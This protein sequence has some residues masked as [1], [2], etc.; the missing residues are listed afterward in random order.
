MP[1]DHQVLTPALRFRV[2]RENRDH[3]SWAQ[4]AMKSSWSLPIF[5][6][7]SICAAQTV[8]NAPGNR[9]RPSPSLPSMG[10]VSDCTADVFDDCNAPQS[11]Q[12]LPKV[13]LRTT[14]GPRRLSATPLQ[15]ENQQGAPEL[16]LF[17]PSKLPA[18]IIN[19]SDFQ[20]FAEDD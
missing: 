2:L 15:L 19:P 5:L 17:T 1:H 3:K 9:A 16:G 10:S 20:L 4:N 13:P 12:S 11:L 6:C 7:C 18:P 14:A 8:L